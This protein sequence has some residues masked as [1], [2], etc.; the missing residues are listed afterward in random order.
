MCHTSA[1]TLS[2]ARLEPLSDEQID[3]AFAEHDKQFPFFSSRWSFEAGIEFA[4][5]I[6]K[7]GGNG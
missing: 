5:G 3:A 1:P 4:N 6:T 2:P 7:D